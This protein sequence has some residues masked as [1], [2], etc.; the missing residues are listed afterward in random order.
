MSNLQIPHEPCHVLLTFRADLTVIDD[1]V[2]R[3]SPEEIE[4]AFVFAMARDV[5]DPELLEKWV[6]HALRTT[7][8]YLLVDSEEDLAWRAKNLRADLVQHFA[9]MRRT[10]L[11]MVFDVLA[12]RLRVERLSGP[13][14]AANLSAMYQ[15]HPKTWL[16][17]FRV[18][19][20][21]PLLN[22][23]AFVESLPAS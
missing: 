8:H 23:H 20:V 14:S 3:V 2:R 16:H 11:Q 10:T 9:T 22:I 17:E 7:T 13:I 19:T 5:A 4:L 18:S 15:D 6:A 21:E 1:Q 12:T